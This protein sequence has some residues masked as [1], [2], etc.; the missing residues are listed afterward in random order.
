MEHDTDA[1]ADSERVAS[2]VDAIDERVAGG[3]PNEGRQDPDARRLPRTVWSEESEHFPFGHGKREIMQR[4][5]SGGVGLAE[6]LNKR[7][8]IRRAV[9]TGS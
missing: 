4:D 1:T 2:H 6:P 3:R 9:V 7:G 5:R 8:H